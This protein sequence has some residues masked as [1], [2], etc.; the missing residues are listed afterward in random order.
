MV[1]FGSA[2]RLSRRRGWEEAYVDYESLKLLLSQIE[3]V[4]EESTTNGFIGGMGRGHDFGFYDEET[5]RLFSTA[6]VGGGTSNSTR[7]QGRGTASGN[8]ASSMKFDFRDELFLESDSSDAYESLS[9]EEFDEHD[10]KHDDHNTASY[11][12]DSIVYDHYEDYEDQIASHGHSHGHH[13]PKSNKD[14]NSVLPSDANFN[15]SYSA[16]SYGSHEVND[17][18]NGSTYES[19]HY[20]SSAGRSYGSDS[21]G[22]G[23][24]NDNV[25]ASSMHHQHD[26]RTDDEKHPI[27]ISKK[28]SNSIVE[29]I[30]PYTGR[31]LWSPYRA[32]RTI[33]I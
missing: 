27:L 6:S 19:I 32:K 8:N 17:S 11:D 26:Y 30:S 24:F 16:P 20:A 13:P 28:R 4:Y 5:S 10:H 21:F 15:F 25:N 33:Q 9:E 12:E 29:L 31:R 7:N 23:Q 22:R 1:G 2:L 14:T 18:T 3:A